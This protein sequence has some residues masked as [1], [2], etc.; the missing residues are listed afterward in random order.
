MQRCGS[1]IAA[2]GDQVP[3]KLAFFTMPLHPPERDF[4]ETLKEDR[5]AFLLADRLGFA[6]GFMGEHATDRA[7]TVTSCVAFLASIAYA[8]KTMVLGTGTVNLTLAHPAVVAGQVAMLDNM[9]EGRFLFGIS[10]GALQ[11]DFEA[12]GVLD[13]NRG[14]MFLEA[15]DHILAL[16]TTAPPYRRRGKH[17][18][19]TTE[20]TLIEEIGQGVMVPTYQKPHPPIVITVVAPQSKGIAPA[21]ARGWMPISANFLMP[22][23]VATHW[24]S[25]VEGCRQGGRVARVEDWRVAKSIFVAD[26][27]R[28]ARR[29]AIEDARSPYR[30]YLAQLM[31]KLISIGR[32]EVFKHD[33]AMP[34]EAVTLDDVLERLVIAGSVDNVVDQ[35][36]AF[37]ETVGDFGTLV[38]AGHDWA[39]PHLAKRSMELMATEVMPCINKAIGARVRLG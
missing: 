12:L 9:L 5:E 24:P 11:S 4:A 34:N 35:I 15:I 39:D 18:T 37:R 32:Y 2:R 22:V 31:R 29:Y 33:P 8:T 20:R 17:W 3:M 14:E 21:A 6:E 36:L 26:D 30:F 28:V 27:D 1:R 38:Y 16:W 25:Y 19:I 7:E 23:G 13:K 10:P